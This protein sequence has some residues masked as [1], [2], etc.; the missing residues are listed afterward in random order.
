LDYPVLNPNGYISL[1]YL[2][3]LFIFSIFALIY[4]I[5]NRMITKERKYI[6]DTDFITRTCYKGGLYQLV[7]GI[8]YHEA[9]N[10][11]EDMYNMIALLALKQSSIALR[12]AKL[13]LWKEQIEEILAN[14]RKYNQKKYDVWVIIPF[15]AFEHEISKVIS[16]FQFALNTLEQFILNDDAIVVTTDDRDFVFPLNEMKDFFFDFITLKYGSRYV[17]NM[18]DVSLLAITDEMIRRGIAVDISKSS[19]VKN[20]HII[21]E[22]VDVEL[23][24]DENDELVKSQFFNEDLFRKYYIKPQYELDDG[25]NNIEMISN[26]V[27]KDDI[28]LKE[29]CGVIYYMLKDKIDEDT[30]IKVANYL[31]GTL[32]N[33]AIKKQN[34]NSIKRYIYSYRKDRDVD[35]EMIANIRK[36]LQ[37]YE[38]PFLPPK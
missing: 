4:V 35:N 8:V 27:V 21:F 10:D 15:L 29:K 33:S 38:I 6:A 17:G 13:M 5:Q 37:D 12:H 19:F 30:I 3:I 36:T 9:D 2:P 7:Y 32:Y 28:T 16:I 24:I 1:L 31:N 14:L 20:G 11:Y 25:I 22:D 18:L 26:S 23:L 34:A